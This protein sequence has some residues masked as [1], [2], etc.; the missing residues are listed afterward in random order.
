MIERSLVETGQFLFERLKDFGD[1]AAP[2]VDGLLGVADT[3]ERTVGWGLRDAP[4][5]R[6]QHLPLGHRRILE[7]IQQ[8]MV[9]VGVKPERDLVERRGRPG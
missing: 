3:E 7:F 2:A 1:A 6:P 5:D 9:E 8:Q 4:S